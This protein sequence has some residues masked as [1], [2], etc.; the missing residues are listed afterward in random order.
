MPHTL[1]LGEVDD[2]ILLIYF[3]FFIGIGWALK[4]RV[5]GNTDFFLS[6]RSIPACPSQ[7]RQIITMAAVSS[8][9]YCR[10]SWRRLACSSGAGSGAKTRSWYRIRTYAEVGC[11]FVNVH[12]RRP[13]LLAWPTPPDAILPRT[14]RLNLRGRV[15]SGQFLMDR[16]RTPKPRFSRR[17][18]A[19]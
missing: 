15:V 19:R 9:Q 18:I 14:G 2:V 11:R 10:S 13:A 6:G 16:I 3:V 7:C 1:S 17:A 12:F 5:K 8:L 4:R